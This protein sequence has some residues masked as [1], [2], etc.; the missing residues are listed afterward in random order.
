MRI[1]QARTSVLTHVEDGHDSLNELRIIPPRE[2][3]LKPFSDDVHSNR[4][5]DPG[6]EVVVAGIVSNLGQDLEP[7][8][9]LDLRNAIII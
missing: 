8:R 6:A 4:V 9:S 2:C 1:N 3:E 7:S 5:V